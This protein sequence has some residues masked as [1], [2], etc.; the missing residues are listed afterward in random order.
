MKKTKKITKGK[1]ARPEK[2]SAYEKKLIYVMAGLCLLSV[3][4]FI[5]VRIWVN[6]EPEFVPPPFDA[7]A[8]QGMPTVDDVSYSRVYQLGMRFSVHLCGRVQVKE[9]G[10]ADIWFTNAEENEVWMK[11]RILNEAGETIAETGLLRPDEYV[12]SVQ[13]TQIPQVGDPITMKVM[14][15]EP[16]TYLSAGAVTLNTI[17]G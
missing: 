13:F 17:V 6:R 14:G 12:R 2:F 1:S 10:T 11:L 7:A 3:L 5:A 15:Y 16:D 8:Q 9:D 4:C